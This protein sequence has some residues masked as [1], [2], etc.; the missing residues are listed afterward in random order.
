MIYSCEKY[1]KYKLE[2]NHII[3]RINNTQIVLSL[4]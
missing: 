4:G 3:C 1:I 2:N